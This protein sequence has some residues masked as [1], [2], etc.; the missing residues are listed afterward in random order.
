MPLD[1]RRTPISQL[2]TPSQLPAMGRSPFLPYLIS[3]RARF[4]CRVKTRLAGLRTPGS[5][6]PLP[7]QSPSTGWSEPL[8]IL[9]TRSLIPVRVTW[10]EAGFER[11]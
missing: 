4:T 3:V 1:G 9:M 8:P 7:S 11:R 5:T 6:R 2:P 10:N